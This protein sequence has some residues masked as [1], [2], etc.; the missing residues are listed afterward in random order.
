MNGIYIA[1]SGAAGALD[2]LTTASSNLANADTP[3][4]RR[5]VNVMESVQGNTPYQ[6]AS[7]S[8]IQKIDGG[9]GPVEATGNPLDMAI[10]GPGFLTVQT[11][12]GNAYTRNGALQV[13]GDGALLAA[14]QPVLG[15]GGNPITLP[16]GRL[17]VGSDGSLSV[18]GQP[19]GK[20]AMADPTGVSM[21]AAGGS[22]Y[23]SASGDDLPADA[24]SQIHQGMLERSTGSEMGEM[25]SMMDV[26]R[27]YESA[28]NAVHL[29]D[30]NQNEAIQAF[31]L[32]A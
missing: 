24:S 28:M 9:Q 7:S 8:P 21:V 6:Y 26:A 29:I 16:A 18:E 2:Q 14:G 12:Q 5:F 11:D 25:V 3:G 27:N 4:Y 17:T 20:L 30:S 19:V 13:T 15:V 22:L 10:V 1:A 31:T 23:R 32:Q